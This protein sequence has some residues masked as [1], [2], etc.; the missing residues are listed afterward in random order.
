MQIRQHW[1]STQPLKK[2]QVTLGVILVS[3][4]VYQYLVLFII[5]YA[6]QNDRIMALMG[7][8]DGTCNSPSGMANVKHRKLYQVKALTVTL[9]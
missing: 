1:A 6:V 2:V 5:K 8:T 4:I 9:N 3:P 7:K